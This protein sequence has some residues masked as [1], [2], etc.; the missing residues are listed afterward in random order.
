MT[1]APSPPAADPARLAAA[2]VSARLLTADA[3]ARLLADYD[4]SGAVGGFLHHLVEAAALTPFQARAAEAGRAGGLTVGPYLLRE[5]ASGGPLGGVFHA[6]CRADGRA[7]VV[8][9]SPLRSPWAALQARRHVRALAAVPPHPAL[10]PVEEIGTAGA[11]HYLAWPAAEGEPVGEL[12]RRAGPLPPAHAA[13]LAATV[14]DALAHLHTHGLTHGLL[15]PGVVL[16]TPAGS[17]RLPAVGMGALLADDLAEPEPLLDGLSAAVLIAATLDYA[18]PEVRRDPTRRGPAADGYALGG[19]LHFLLTGTPPAADGDLLAR[20]AGPRPPVRERTPDLPAGFAELV[21]RLL[22]PDPAG[23]PGDLAA[24]AAECRA[25]ADAVPPPPPP[26]APPRLTAG[27]RPVPAPP[28]ELAPVLVTLS[29][30]KPRPP[31]DG[32]AAPTSDGAISFDLPEPPEPPG[33]VDTALP[34]GGPPGV[35]VATPPPAYL[36]APPADAQATDRLRSPGAATPPEAR[37]GLPGPAAGGLFGSLARLAGRVLSG[38]RRPGDRLAVSVF[39]PAHLAPGATA[40]LLVY[41][42]PPG[43]EAG[44]RT[45]ARATLPGCDRLAG[46]PADRPVGRGDAVGLHLS[47]RGGGVA[48]PQVGFTWRGQPRGE[49]FEVFVPT[50]TPPGPV[51]AVLSVGRNGL[52]NGRVA[53]EVAVR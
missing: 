35:S 14:A 43:A 40:R 1:P 20:L 39:G 32:P 42:H 13:R 34:D 30:L 37:P 19:V 52:A 8:K 51:P 45:L 29:S 33:L 28:A 21:E 23:R 41:A 24:V 5:Q 6:T 53:F 38:G 2:L 27:R 31:A 47:I 46:G 4:R 12:V 15:A 25:L 16:V 49:G 22:A 9:V 48:R 18:A 50:G 26:P 7:A 44:V 10:A 17:T 3:A 11:A 36:A